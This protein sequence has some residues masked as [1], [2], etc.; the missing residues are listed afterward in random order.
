MKVAYIS[1]GS[2]K[3]SRLGDDMLADICLIQAAFQEHCP[4][5]IEEWEDGFRRDAT[6]Q[7]EIAFW[8]RAA[9]IYSALAAD[10]P[11]PERRRD[12]Y[13]CLVVCM[14]TRPDMFSLAFHPEAITPEE[15]SL[16]A[17]AYY[18]RKV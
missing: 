13:R 3:H 1:S 16:V 7:R 5:S 8:F 11:S 12:V 9:E 14:V 2:I 6:P 18:G 15:A 17:E 10:D 4:L